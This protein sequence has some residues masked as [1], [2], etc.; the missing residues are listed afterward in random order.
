MDALARLL[1]HEEDAV[2]LDPYNVLIRSSVIGGRLVTSPSKR[3]S[4]S[5]DWRP[6]S[7]DDND[8]DISGEFRNSAEDR[9][10]EGIQS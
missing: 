7:P 4:L 1:G 10:K 8:D 3:G 6:A 9:Y 2:F 5:P